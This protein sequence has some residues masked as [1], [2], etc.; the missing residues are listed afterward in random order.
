MYLSRTQFYTYGAPSGSAGL[1]ESVIDSSISGSCGV[2]DSFLRGAHY[3]LPLTSTPEIIFKIA[4]DLS[5][6]AAHSVNGF[7]YES[8]YDQVLKQRYDQSMLLL[9]MLRSKEILLDPAIDADPNTLG[10]SGRVIAR[11]FEVDV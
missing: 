10:R 2:I 11:N 5:A 9:E 3:D 1:T 7:N 8:T 4:G 6:Y